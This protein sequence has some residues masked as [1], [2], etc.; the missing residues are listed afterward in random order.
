RGPRLLL[1]INNIYKELEKWIE[2]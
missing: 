2:V 1:A